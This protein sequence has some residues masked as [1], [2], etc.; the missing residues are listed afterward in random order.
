MAAKPE[1]QFIRAC[2]TG[3]LD[4]V[5]QLLRAGLSP[6]VRDSDGLTGLIWAGRK[7]QVEVAKV[8]L[9]ESAD[10]EAKDRRGRTAIFHAI[11][12]KRYEYVQFIASRGAALTHVDLHGWTALDLA[13]M[14]RNPKMVELLAKLGAPRRSTQ[15]PPPPTLG[16]NRFG[17]G[18]GATGGP[19]LPIEVERIHVQ[20][21]TLFH[22]WRGEYSPAVEGFGFPR[23][24]DGSLIRYTEQLNILGPQKAQRGGNWLMVKIGVPE[25]W[26][27][28]P[29]PAYKKLLSDSIETGLHSMIALLRRNKHE[30]NGDLLL[31]DWSKVKKEFL[32]VPAPPFA[33]EKQR[34]AMRI[35]VD[36]M[37][38]RFKEKKE[39]DA[40]QQS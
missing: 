4:V 40:K 1:T 31:T 2:S 37:L 34:A 30:V 13:S 36:E 15:D 33:A 6:D 12:Y 21:H 35:Q 25:E 11:A 22:R 26:W 3:K 10:L 24:V 7:G 19:N 9:A 18:G 39:A 29:E 20:L 28:Q 23:Y 27:S 17:S 16:L 32:E 38:S 14:P 5:R 8:L